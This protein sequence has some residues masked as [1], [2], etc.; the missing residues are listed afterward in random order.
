MIR[1]PPRST[2]SS[3][4]AA[5]DVYKR[6]GETL[7]RLR[8]TETGRTNSSRDTR[9]QTPTWFD[10]VTFE[11][12]KSMV[13]MTNRESIFPVAAVTV[14]FFI[15]GFEYGLVAQLN[16]QFQTVAHDTP[17][18]Q[19]GLHAAYFAGYAVAPLTFGRLVL[20]KWGFK[21]CYSV[22]LSIYACGTLVFWVA[23]VL[24]SFPT[25]IIVNFVVGMG[26]STLEIAANP[27]ILLCGPSKYAA[28]RL[29]L[30]QG[31]KLLDLLLPQSSLQKHSSNSRTTRR[32]LLVHSGH[33]LVS[34]SSLSL[35]RSYTTMFLYLR[36]PTRSFK[37]LQSDW[38][39]RTKPNMARQISSGLFL[40]L[41]PYPNSAMSEP[42][43]HMPRPL[44]SIFDLQDPTLISQTGWPSLMVPLP[45]HD[46]S[47]L[48]SVCSSNLEFS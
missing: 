42:R 35:S 24:T 11:N 27:F 1:R 19:A 14:L 12:K 9:V 17:G 23:A 5:S 33:I 30:S 29:N 32:H 3:S 13:H 8:R 10:F 47:Q 40:D 6:Q 7:D 26:L 34:R 43:K 44:M 20:K 2:L 37:M 21:A 22:G 39:M 31:S 15:W 28:V 41:A 18:Q 16:A 25:Y 36:L 4:S 38:I 46:S 48:D 45:D